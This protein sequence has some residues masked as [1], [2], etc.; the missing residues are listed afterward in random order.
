M[1]Q[2]TRLPDVFL[3]PVARVLNAALEADPSACSALEELTGRNIAVHISDFSL[4][5]VAH[6]EGHAIDLTGPVESPDAEVTGTLSQLAAAG[7][8]G[9]PKG[10]QVS[11]DAELVHGLS[12]TMARLPAA[13]WERVARTI[14]DVPARG[15]ERLGAELMS[16]FRD[17]RERL[18]GSLTEYLQY[19]LRA[20]PSRDELDAYM[21]DVDRLRDDTERLAKR[22]ERLERR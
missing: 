12:R 7:R 20:V 17:T 22:F 18:S 5:V 10:L 15:L 14:G 1:N 16:V 21:S 11:G 3:K 8:S 6:I 19:E 4:T 2:Q 9:S 13:A